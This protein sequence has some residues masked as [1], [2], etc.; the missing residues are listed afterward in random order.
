MFTIRKS[1][2]NTKRKMKKTKFHLVKNH[3]FH[4]KKEIPQFLIDLFAGSFAGF[5]LVVSAFPLDTLKVKIQTS[6]IADKHNHHHTSIIGVTKKLFAEEG[7]FGFYAGMLSP[8][9]G[10]IFINSYSFLV[11]NILGRKIFKTSNFDELSIPKIMCFSAVSGLFL[12]F[13]DTPFD[14]IKCKMQHGGIREQ[15]T[16]CNLNTTEKFKSYHC[17]TEVVQKFGFKSL[18]QGY[19]ATLIRDIPSVSAYFVSYYASRK[20]FLNRRK[21][22]N[23]SIKLNQLEILASG[24]IAGICYQFFYPLDL[25]KSIMQSDYS[26]KDKRVCNTYFCTVKKVYSSNRSLRGFYRGYLGGLSGS[27]V[28]CA[29]QFLCYEF[30]HS[31]LKKFL[32]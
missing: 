27:I 32:H 9:I 14:L 15:L 29:F 12:S 5:G 8:L 3:D 11:F 6:H 19:L 23:K 4:Q 16:H 2:K 31:N 22:N 1:Q 21:K 13:I 7:I 25:I 30:A 26:S 18:Y 24:G 28:G 10:T 17:C 20:Y